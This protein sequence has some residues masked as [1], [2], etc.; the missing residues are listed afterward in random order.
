MSPD[1]VFSL[2]NALALLAWIA[3]IASPARAPWSR[4][5]CRPCTP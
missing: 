5:C 1:A 4:W 3:L 2:C